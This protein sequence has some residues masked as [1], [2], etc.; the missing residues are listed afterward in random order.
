MRPFRRLR[1]SCCCGEG[2]APL[3]NTSGPC[4]EAPVARGLKAPQVAANL[5]AA[6][7]TIRGQIIWHEQHFAEWC[8]SGFTLDDIKVAIR[9]GNV[10]EHRTGDRLHM[11]G[12]RDV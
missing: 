4:T 1:T 3:T 2:N 8:P 9:D 11:L 7:F 5:E 6:G 12:G 10:R